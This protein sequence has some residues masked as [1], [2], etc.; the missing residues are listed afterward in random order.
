MC[1]NCQ[2][3]NV[4]VEK[5]INGSYSVLFYYSIAT[6]PKQLTCLYHL[7]T[8]MVMPLSFNSTKSVQRHCDW[9]DWE[10]STAR[11]QYDPVPDCLKTLLILTVLTWHLHPWHLHPWQ[12]PYWE[13]NLPPQH[14]EG[15]VLPQLAPIKLKSITINFVSNLKKSKEL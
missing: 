14:R 5:A 10:H 15:S 1:L 13:G 2:K 11:T 3:W 9:R 12:G 7:E 4:T 8:L 6:Q